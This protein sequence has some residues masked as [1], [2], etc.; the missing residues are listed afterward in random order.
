[1]NSA[2]MDLKDVLVSAG[3]G[4]FG[5]STGWGIY[6]GFEPS[7]PD[8]VITLYDTGS[9]QE[10]NPAYL[11]DFPTIQIRVRG[12]KGDYPGAFAKAFAVK[13]VLLGLPPQTINGTRYDGVWMV[14]D[15]S[16][17]GTSEDRPVF[18]SNWRIAR[19]PATGGN[20]VSL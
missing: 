13:D 5:G 6:I 9:S 12:A 14:S 4:T 7:A 16:Y 15:V 11:L 18:T 20:R 3:I 2:A 8:T 19:E 10:P 1:M 17:I